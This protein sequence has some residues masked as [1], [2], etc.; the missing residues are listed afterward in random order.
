MVEK[1]IIVIGTGMA[2]YGAQEALREIG[3]LKNTIFYNYGETIKIKKN[4]YDK[5][6]GFTF[7]KKT[8]FGFSLSTHKI[9]KSFLK[10]FYSK[11]SGGLSDFWSG[12]VSAFPDEE[13]EHRN[14]LFLKKYYKEFSKKINVLGG[15][16][17]IPNF[18]SIP[19][20][21]K[22]PLSEKY[23]DIIGEKFNGNEF[24]FDITTNKILC[25]KTNCTM[26]G[27]CFNGCPENIIFRPAKH[28]PTSKLVNK[29]I[30]KIEFDGMK[31]KIFSNGNLEDVCDKLLLAMGTYQTI[32][33]LN[34]SNLIDYKKIEI[35][36][37]STILFP[38]YDKLKKQLT[39]YKNYGYA[40][41]LITIHGNKNNKEFN[42]QISLVPFN[43]FFTYNIFGNLIGKIFRNRF[44]KS[45][46]L[47]MFFSSKSE[48]NTYTKKKKN[49][50][51]LKKDNTS[52]AKLTLKKIIKKINLC[53]INLTII[54]LLIKNKSSIHYSSNLL[55]E[56]VNF[57]KRSEIKKD[58]FVLDGNIFPGKP[59]AQGNS[60]SIMCGAYAIVKKTFKEGNGK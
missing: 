32:S 43:H 48:A 23:K 4:V 2:G 9:K 39:T 18:F 25:N 10:L 29:K 49:I 12:S 19:S 41:T 33:L 15:Q 11:T 5:F 26:C 30:D 3:M 46:S 13:L 40:N 24:R 42:S 37:S 14:L 45:F 44:Y 60:F 59:I 35:Y 52:K 34:N 55:S 27:E 22:F 58:L 1:K 21:F 8:E 38:I 28:F 7:P 20:N 51:M 57:F 6:P 16:E 47:G 53:D 50:L 56:K 54:P 31:W 17:K 36:D